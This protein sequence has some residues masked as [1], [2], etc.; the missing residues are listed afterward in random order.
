MAQVIRTSLA[1]ILPHI[2][3]RLMTVLGWPAERVLIAPPEVLGWSGGQA[4]QLV[5]FWPQTDHFQ[6]KI[7][8]GAG[9]VDTR[10]TEHI[11][12]HLR[13][14]FGVDEATNLQSWLTDSTLGHWVAREG[15]LDALTCYSPTD[16][17]DETGNFLVTEPMRYVNG[18]KP[19]KIAGAPL[20]WGQSSLVF[21][22]TYL[23]S[24]DQTYQ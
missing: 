16:T 13:T 19:L 6:S 18:S 24:L 23:P 8:D 15:L 12:F 4:D 21:E 3:T 7:F 22:L 9:R 5:A 1:T 10:I 2:Q 14:R 11:L 17:D 20:S